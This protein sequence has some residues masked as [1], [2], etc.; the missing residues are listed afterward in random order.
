MS[1]VASKLDSAYRTQQISEQIKNCVPNLKNA[2]KQMN[3][4]GISEQMANFES[5]F[6]DLDVKTSDITGVLDSVTGSS[7]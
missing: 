5:V 4:M 6:E 2:L 7:A 1:A 3:K